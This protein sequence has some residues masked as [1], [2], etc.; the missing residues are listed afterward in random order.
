MTAWCYHEVA[1]VRTSDSTG[2]SRVG[3]PGRRLRCECLDSLHDELNVAPDESALHL[4]A[5]NPAVLRR[6]DRT[7]TQIA[8]ARL[9]MV[10][11]Q[12]L[13][14]SNEHAWRAEQPPSWPIL[15]STP[16]STCS[17]VP[18]RTTR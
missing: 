3:D 6:L 10:P 2:H 16:V 1:G 7:T 4:L 15:C 13:D 12:T 14:S 9:L 17:S 18:L 11:E 5:A 8:N